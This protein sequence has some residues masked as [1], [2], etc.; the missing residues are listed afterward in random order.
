MP[1]LLPFNFELM[2]WVDTDGG[3]RFSVERHLQITPRLG[4][5]GEAGYDT[6]EQ[7][8]ERVGLSYTLAKDFSLVGRW[9]SDHGWGGGL[10]WRFWVHTEKG[11][12][13]VPRFCQGFP[14]PAWVRAGKEPQPDI[15][16]ESGYGEKN[17][18][19]SIRS[20][21]AGTGIRTVSP[22]VLTCNSNLQERCHCHRMRST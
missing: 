1:D 17:E 15:V 3:A 14:V 22:P 8:E 6:H 11:T 5:F 12:L 9:H 10:Q 4:V 13:S 19:L 18:A 2:A 7:W 20:L 21:D 16:S